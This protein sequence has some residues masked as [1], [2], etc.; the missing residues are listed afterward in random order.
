VSEQHVIAAIDVGT[1]SIHMVVARATNT[2]FQTITREKA[3]AR[4]GEGGGDMKKLSAAAMDRGVTAL[5]NMKRIADAHN[6]PIYAVATSAVREASNNSEFVARVA[7]EA[8]IDVEVISGVEEARLIHLGVLQAIPLDGRRSILIDIGG[9][10]TEVVVA[11]QADELFVRSYKLGA[12][13]LTNRFLADPS[14]RSADINA[15]RKFVESTLEPN[16]REVK[17][18]GH[19]IA[20][21]SS[22]TAE[23]IARISWLMHNSEQPR[24]VNAITFTRDDLDAVVK[25]LATCST[26]DERR[27]IP[28]MDDARAD[29]IMAGALILQTIAQSFGIKE[30]TY[31]DYSLREGVLLEAARRMDLRTDA[32]V[33]NVAIESARKLSMR[34]DEDHQHS[35]HVAFLAC[36]MFDQLEEAFEIEQSDRI[37]LEAA[38]L[39]ANVGITVSHSR[40]HMHSYYIIRNAELVGFND[41]EIEL[42]AQIAR[43]HRKS[44]PKD[45]HP[46]FAALSPDDQM[47][48]RALAGILRVAIGLD[49]THDGRCKQ[50]IVDVGKKDIVITAK[51]DKG[52]DLELNIY[53]AAERVS[54]MENT[55]QHKVAFKA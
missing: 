51:G 16:K 20:I 53:A 47:R 48:V 29:I 45:Q 15:C 3:V 27:A 13:R 17:R 7:R 35:E 32:A 21:V 36:S 28:G 43:Y 37:L 33:P 30:F 46:E 39:L 34:C 31:S 25:Q 6:A 1:N 9:G 38:A 40:H 23:T 52:V 22:G 5:R 50:A 26:V 24:S 41:H 18:L 44:E 54:L 2:G 19:D 11:D 49:R 12:V 14:N 55:F 42:V 10:S 8:G 4:L